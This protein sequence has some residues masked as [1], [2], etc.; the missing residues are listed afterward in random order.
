MKN[1]NGFFIRVVLFVAIV[2]AMVLLDAH[3]F[4]QAPPP[5]NSAV[6]NQFSST[7][8][9]AIQSNRGE[10]V[11]WIELGVAAFAALILFGQEVAAFFK[12]G[13]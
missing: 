12:G 8:P 7:Q 9:I 5:P 1:D 3:W 2:V 13:K 4:Q 10:W 6:I 11:T